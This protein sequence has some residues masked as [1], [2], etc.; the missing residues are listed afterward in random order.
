MAYKPSTNNLSL[1]SGIYAI[2][3]ATAD[4]AYMAPQNLRDD[5]GIVVT[6][7]SLAFEWLVTVDGNK[8]YTLQVEQTKEYAVTC[9]V[10]QETI[11]RVANNEQFYSITYAS[12]KDGKTYYQIRTQDNLYFKYNGDKK[13]T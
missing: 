11:V 3:S 6:E 7:E 2:D 10:Q 5:S 13:A 1:P 9:K 4:G 8:N 12:E